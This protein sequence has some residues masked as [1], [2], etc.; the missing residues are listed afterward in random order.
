MSRKRGEG[1]PRDA[2]GDENP[3]SYQLHAD[4]TAADAPVGKSSD[5]DDERVPLSPS[6][7]VI[8]HPEMF[9]NESEGDNAAD[10]D[11]DESYEEREMTLQELMYSSSSF[12]AIV[13]PGKSEVMFEVST[14]CKNMAN[15]GNCLG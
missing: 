11:D 7:A 1:G 8:P 3:V 15:T 6:R 13:V 5:F 2:E 9:R 12:Y 14:V 10:A 4:E